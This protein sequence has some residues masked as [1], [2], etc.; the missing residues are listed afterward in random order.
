MLGILALPVVA[1]K[2][3]PRPPRVE[4]VAQKGSKAADKKE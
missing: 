2:L 4:N 1:K 3:T